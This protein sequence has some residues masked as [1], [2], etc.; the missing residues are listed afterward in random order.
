LFIA[1]LAIFPGRISQK[2][3]G[4]IQP[5]IKV[6]IFI[7]PF[8]LFWKTHIL[9]KILCV[10]FNSPE[11]KKLKKKKKKPKKK[12]SKIASTAYNMK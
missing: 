6:K 1:K 3:L 11:K 5:E 10:F 4:Y 2:F 8:L 12:G 7:H 9:F